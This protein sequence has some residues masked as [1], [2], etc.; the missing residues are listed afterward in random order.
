[1]LTQNPF[2][3]GRKMPENKK[4]LR[5]FVALSTLPLLGV[6][7]AFGLV[8]QSDF[9]L[10]SNKVDIENIA[11]PKVAVEKTAADYWRNERVQNI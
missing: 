10:A 2:G 8:P 6:V 11:L 5:W 1:M 7:T 3:Q 4:K 9:D